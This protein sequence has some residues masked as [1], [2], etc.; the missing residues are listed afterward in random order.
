MEDVPD[1]PEGAHTGA[2]RRRRP[3]LRVALPA[4][5]V[6]DGWTRE[7]STV[8]LSEDGVL[9]AGPDFPSG[10]RVRL[11]IELAE[12]GWREVSAD[13]VRRE[14]REGEERLAAC[15]ARA[16][17]EGGRDAIR[18]FFAARLAAEE[19]RAA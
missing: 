17:T 8:D 2:D 6:G 7:V 4:R 5:V 9:V 1:H 13:V 11:E 10:S 15:F 18:A 16:A 19:R 14:P 3:R 12:L